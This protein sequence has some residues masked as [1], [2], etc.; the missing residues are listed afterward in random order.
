MLVLR[1]ELNEI[2]SQVVVAEY[3]RQSDIQHQDRKAQEEIASLQHIVHGLFDH[4][5]CFRK[6]HDEYLDFL[7]S[8]AETIEESSISKI[9][10]DRLQM[11]NERLRLEIANLRHSPAPPQVKHMLV[12]CRNLQ[13]LFISFLHSVRYC[14]D[15]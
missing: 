8:G 12:V 4:F 3:Q 5:V 9:E 13:L 1:K 11:E 7:F 15:L 10:I 14:V 2:K 6:F